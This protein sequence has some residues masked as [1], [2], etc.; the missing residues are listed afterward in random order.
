VGRRRFAP[1]RFGWRTSQMAPSPAT[2]RPCRALGPAPDNQALLERWHRDRDPAAHDE[3][4]ERFLPLA[5]KLAGSYPAGGEREDLL[6]V[7]ALGL[8]N[9]LERYDPG[10]GTAFVSFAIP[11]ILGELRRY[12]RD[13]GWAVRV[14]RHVQEL[15]QRCLS[16]RDELTA[17][18][19]RAPTVEELAA[20]CDTTAERVVEARAT[21]SAHFA[22]SLNQ[23][24]G[25]DEEEQ[26]ARLAC[27]EAGLARVE[28]SLELRYLL[29]PL[30]PR[31]RTI[32]R[33]RFEDEL[34]QAEIGRLVG[35]SQMQVSR[36]IRRCIAELAPAA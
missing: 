21:A 15:A 2:A 24:R 18:L 7:A 16:T 36:V 1:R 23:P 31:E 4:V 11:T 6:Q 26:V 33:L 28:A 19:G 8:L 20:A 5:R 3:L 32:M 30:A 14:P 12:F 34:T 27:E 17:K 13:H 25:E 22:V 10:R 35:L 9:A 29:E